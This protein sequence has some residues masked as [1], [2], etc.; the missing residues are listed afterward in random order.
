MVPMYVCTKSRYHK[1]A[2]I[3]VGTYH[4]YKHQND[5]LCTCMHSNTANLSEPTACMNR[6]ITST[7][8]RT[9]QDINRLL[10]PRRRLQLATVYKKVYFGVK[11][12]ALPPSKPTVVLSLNEGDDKITLLDVF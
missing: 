2:R 11:T 1:Y 8:P 9:W 6:S 4:T 5:L 10:G 7:L 3:R 12:I